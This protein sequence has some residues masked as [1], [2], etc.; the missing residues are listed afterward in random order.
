MTILEKLEIGVLNDLKAS[1]G[2]PSIPPDCRSSGAED[3]DEEDDPNSA[4]DEGPRMICLWLELVFC[5]DPLP[6]KEDDEEEEWALDE[7]EF[8]LDG[9][10]SVISS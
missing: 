7:L 8:F 2:R 4:R 9:G 10:T 5:F 1:R 3:E 6:R